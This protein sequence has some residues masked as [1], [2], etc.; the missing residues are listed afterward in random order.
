MFLKL[1]V[2]FISLQEYHSAS[3]MTW[4]AIFQR[5]INNIIKEE[6]VQATFAYHDVVTV[7]GYNER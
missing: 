3:Q 5:P 7:C 4:V 6:N 2:T 1:E